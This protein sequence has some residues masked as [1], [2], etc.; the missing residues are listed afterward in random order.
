LLSE[1]GYSVTALTGKSSAEAWLKRLGASNILLRSEFDSG[2]PKPLAKETWAACVDTAGGR[3]LTHALT[4]AKY[5][6]T[7]TACGLVAGMGLAGAT[8]APFIL[9]GV[10]LIGVDSVFLPL[11]DR[12]AAYARYT[13]RLIDSRKLD[14]VCDSEKQTLSL[15][16]V[17]DVAAKMLKGDVQ[18][19]FIVKPGQK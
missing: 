19:R 15:E 13:Q 9:R 11:A 3:I 1:L 16:Q 10:K 2:E 6:A 8:V 17:P 12:K 4:T 7:V 18:G 14:L 5:G